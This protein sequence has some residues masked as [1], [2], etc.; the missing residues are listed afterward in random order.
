M[1][2]QNNGSNNKKDESFVISNYLPLIAQ[3][4]QKGKYI[5]PVCEGHNLSI[6]RDGLKYSCFNGCTGNQIAHKLREL[7]GEFNKRAD[8]KDLIQVY[9]A[10]PV[11]TKNN[12][13][14][15]VKET[16]L[17]LKTEYIL[18]FYKDIIGD[19]LRYNLRTKE[20]ELEGKVL[21]LDCLRVWTQEQYKVSISNQ[22][23]ALETVFYLSL[24]NSYDP[25]KIF[26]EQC[27]YDYD[28]IVDGDFHIDELCQLLFGVSEPL[29]VEY[30]HRWLISLI[31]RVYNPGCK[32]DE[33]FILYGEPDCY[34]STFFK[35]IAGEWFTD[36]MMATDTDNLL[37]MAKNWIVEWSELDHMTAKTYHGT[38]KAFLSRSEDMYRVPYARDTQR[39]PRASIIVGSTNRD[40][41]LNDPTGNRRFW[42]IPVAEGYKIPI[43][44]VKEQR[45]KILG[46]AVWKFLDDGKWQLPDSFKEEQKEANRQ[47]EIDDSWL[48]ALR[49]WLGCQSDIGISEG[50]K[51]LEDLGYKHNFSRTDEMRMGDVL[52]RSGFSRKRTRRGDERIYRYFKGEKNN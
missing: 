31:A 21:N 17:V 6:H 52:K 28:P 15:E 20:V 29:Y 16:D 10:K 46:W 13:S 11:K 39:I 36:A 12:S 24:K 37:I 41:F 18:P 40:N 30:L 25:V 14:L 19:K 43:D 42:V 50:L 49:E 8:S 5:C 51:K 48:E 44:F 23:Y 22:S 45:N 26:L 35:T 2:T 32:M 1:L 33:A 4:D 7:N 47:W 38:I 34:K 27:Y 3:S 9:T